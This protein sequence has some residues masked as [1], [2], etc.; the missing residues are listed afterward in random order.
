MDYIAPTDDEL[1]SMTDEEIL[2]PPEGA[3]VDDLAGRYA[4]E[5]AVPEDE[6]EALG[7]GPGDEE[8]VDMFDMENHCYIDLQ[9]RRMV[10]G[11]RCRCIKPSAVAA[12]RAHQA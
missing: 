11:L 8:I 12:D 9:R 3:T 10:H 5:L 4:I 1:Q 7:I 6:L 2:G